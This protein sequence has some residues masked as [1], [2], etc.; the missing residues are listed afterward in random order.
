VALAGRRLRPGVARSLAARLTR[1]SGTSFYYA[2]RVLPAPKRRAIYALYSLC[3]AL[4]DCVDEPDGGGEAGLQRWLEEIDRSYA[5]RPQTELGREL[6]EA[7]A[8]FPIPR[9]SFAEV[10]DGC[11]MD[12]VGTRYATFDELRVYCRRV[13]GAVG[14]ASIEIFGYRDAA[15]RAYAEELGLALQLTNI[16]RD[17][18]DDAARGRLY[19]PLC[20]LQRAGIDP[21]EFLAAAV[22]EG[23][24]PEPMAALLCA[25]AER[26]RSHYERAAALLP[27]RDRRSMVAAEIM[28]AVYRALLEELV[29][30]RHPLGVRVTLSRPRKAWIALRTLA[31]VRLRG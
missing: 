26:A 14:L 12:L 1:T 5:G 28:G 9:A 2:F 20:E 15:A 24:P 4:D 11:R 27:A 10:A 22:R 23:A 31:R 29:R 17:V 3:R 6:A 21:A 18:S 30:R 8:R 13:A 25:Q 7:L 16:L 19:L